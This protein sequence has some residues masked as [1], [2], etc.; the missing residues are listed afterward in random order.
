MVSRQTA[1]TASS[2]ADGS[3][4]SLRHTAAVT[5]DAARVAHVVGV[6]ELLGG[7]E[8]ETSE[9]AG[10]AQRMAITS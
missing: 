4:L 9:G 3:K 10:L 1:N 5:P 2:V 7:S 8:V 6:L